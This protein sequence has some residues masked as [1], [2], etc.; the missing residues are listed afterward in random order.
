MSVVEVVPPDPR[1]AQALPEA[2]VWVKPALGANLLALHHI[3]STSVPGLAAKPIVD[4]LGIVEDLNAVG[5]AGTARLE[6][7]GFEAKGAYGIPGR[8]YFRR[9]APD[10]TRTHHLHVFAQGAP[11]VEQHLAFRD[12]LRAHPAEAT[13]YG[14]LKRQLAAQHPNDMAAY[15]EGKHSFIQRILAKARLERS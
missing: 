13:A 2:E 10:G 4:L 15:M 3:G 9:N 11:E 8:L 14:E 6:S 5:A 12:H 7:A 1:W